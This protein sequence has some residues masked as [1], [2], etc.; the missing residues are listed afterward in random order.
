MEWRPLERGKLLLLPALPRSAGVRSGGRRH[1]GIG[2]MA[3]FLRFFVFPIF[4]NLL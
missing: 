1:F 2:K 4:L 3:D